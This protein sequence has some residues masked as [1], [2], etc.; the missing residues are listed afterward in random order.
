MVER[1]ASIPCS[2]KG[3]G[4]ILSTDLS[5]VKVIVDQLKRNTTGST[6]LRAAEAV[7]LC[8]PEDE[9]VGDV[10]EVVVETLCAGCDQ[11]LAAGVDHFVLCACSACAFLDS[12]EAAAIY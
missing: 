10:R 2:T 4:P 12:H 5:G 3:F 1:S 8:G 6:Q 9:G 7:S 11:Q